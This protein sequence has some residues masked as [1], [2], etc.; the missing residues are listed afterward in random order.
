[1][2]EYKTCTKCGQTKELFLFVSTYDKRRQ[3][4][5][6]SSACRSCKN[7]MLRLWQRSNKDKVAAYARTF[8]SKHPDKVKLWQKNRPSNKPQSRKKLTEAEKENRRISRLAKVNEARAAKLS[9]PKKC[10]LCHLVLPR[11]NFHN[12]ASNW[13]GK[14]TKCKPCRKAVNSAW[15]LNNPEKASEQR[16]RRRALQKSCETKLVTHKEIKRLMQQPCLYCGKASEHIDHIIPLSRGGRHSIGNLTGAC[17]NCNLSKGSKF[18]M[19]WKKERD[20]RPKPTGKR[21]A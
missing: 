13:D 17:A 21:D 7:E 20:A 10:S 1:M 12:D 6:Y 9:Q 19:E 11:D 5:Y 14:Q 4:L 18:I 3:K 8:R 16:Q 2:E 15:P